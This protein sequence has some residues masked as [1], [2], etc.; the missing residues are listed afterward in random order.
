[1]MMATAT[2]QMVSAG[3]VLG[4]GGCGP[5][6]GSG[7]LT[8]RRDGEG[9]AGLSRDRHEA[10]PGALQDRHVVARERDPRPSRGGSDAE[11]PLAVLARD[12]FPSAFE[13]P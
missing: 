9:W 6:H 2:R 13:G 12:W 10:S 4:R 1:M 7:S 11:G 3:S 5:F 8:L